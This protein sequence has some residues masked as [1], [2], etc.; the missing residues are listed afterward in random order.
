M[1]AAND[2][3]A[4]GMTPRMELSPIST[5]R[6]MLRPLT[7]ADIPAIFGIFSNPAVMRY[8]SSSHWTEMVQAEKK[9]AS[10]L[11]GYASG[12]HFTYAIIRSEDNRLIGTLSL[13]NIVAQ[14]RRADI[15]YALG[16]PYWGAG[17]MHEALTAW[18]RHA[19]ETLELNRLEADIDPRNEGSAKSLER[20][21]FLREGFLRERWIVGGQ[22]SDTYLY[23]LIARDWHARL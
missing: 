22:V 20:Q 5:Q 9:M 16:E 8:W 10:V 13:F 3:S 17:Y 14:S 7:P 19:F 23:G 11:E 12:E 15:G 21:G 4:R 2:A 1:D 6:L 18:V